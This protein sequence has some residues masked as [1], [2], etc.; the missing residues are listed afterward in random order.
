[1]TRTPGNARSGW[2]KGLRRAVE[3]RRIALPLGFLLAVSTLPAVAQSREERTRLTEDE[4][5]TIAIFRDASRGVVH[6]E[7]RA[8]TEA[9][10]LL[11]VQSPTDPYLLELKLISLAE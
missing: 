11:Q 3:A 9:F 6:V 7:S 5:N 8:T 1:M 10:A 4:R 2:I